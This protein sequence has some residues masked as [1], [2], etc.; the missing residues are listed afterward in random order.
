WTSDSKFFNLWTL[1]LTP[2]VSRGLSGLQ[3][4]TKACTVGFPA[5]EAFGLELSHCWLPT[6]PVCRQPI[7]GVHLVIILIHSK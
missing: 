2:V 4:Q 6:S 5:F 3:P 1:G 7:A